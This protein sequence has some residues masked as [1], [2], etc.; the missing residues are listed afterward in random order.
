MQTL[1]P[2][3]LRRRE[4]TKL[5]GLESNQRT[6]DPK[7]RRPCQQSTGQCEPPAGF[8]PATFSVQ[9]S[10]A[11]PVAPR[12][13]GRLAMRR[14]NDGLRRL[15]SRASARIRT[16]GLSLTRRALLPT[17]LQ[18]RGYQGWNRT[19]VL[20]IQSQ[21]GMPATLLVSRAEGASRTHR[22]RVLSSRGLPIAVTPAW[23]AARDLNPD[24][25]IKSQLHNRSCSRRGPRRTW[26]HRQEP[27]LGPSGF[28]PD[29]L[30]TEL[31]RHRQNVGKQGLE[32]RP[33]G[34]GPSALTLTPHPVGGPPGS[35]TPNLLLARESL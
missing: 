34:P 13:R 24:P 3:K 27:N 23:C 16:A 15:T 7:S 2:T 33:L 19:S 1:I 18:R 4:R 29:A 12:R 9:A 11:C 8:E 28:Q 30:P 32:P 26:R 35:R 25:L 10:C 5:T 14:G 21:G 22:P 17:E 6:R 31:R 20:L